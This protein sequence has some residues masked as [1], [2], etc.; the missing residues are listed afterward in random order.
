MTL[1]DLAKLYSMTRGKVS[2]VPT[3]I[4]VNSG[5]LFSWELCVVLESHEHVGLLET[6]HV[7]Q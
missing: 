4:M 5:W 1:R 7:T 2:S 3:K 6:I